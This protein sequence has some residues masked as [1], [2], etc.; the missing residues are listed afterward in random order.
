M[1]A[2]TVAPVASHPRAV[3]TPLRIVDAFLEHAEIHGIRRFTMDEVARRAGLARITIY[4]HFPN[5]KA[6]LKFAVATEV[7]RFFIELDGATI[8]NTD[9]ESWIT[10]VFVAAFAQ[11]RQHNLLQRTLASEADILLPLITGRGSVML[12]M[13]RQWLSAKLRDIVEGTKCAGIDV[14]E[15]AE[16][17]VRLMQ[18]VLINPDSVLDLDR[19]GP[20]RIARRWIVPMMR[21][22][23]TP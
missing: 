7:E 5:K 19:D 8:E 3:E 6:L 22:Q 20:Q 21:A 9:P 12:V 1:L 11:L 16:L 10:D 2:S 15:T 13:S 14:E 18:S 4:S 23:L 17:A